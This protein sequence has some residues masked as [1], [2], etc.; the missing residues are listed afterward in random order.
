MATTGKKWYRSRT[1]WTNLV[2]LVAAVLASE[3]GID[4]EPEETA[5]IVTV[6]NLILRLFTKQPLEL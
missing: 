1:V 5:A 2:M 6:I 4:L 3:A